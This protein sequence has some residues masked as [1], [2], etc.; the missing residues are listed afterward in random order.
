M[1]VAILSRGSGWH[2]QDLLRAGCSRSLSADALD[3][4]QLSAGVPLRQPLDGYD[5]AIIRTMPAGSL[6]QIIFR[7][8]ALHAAADRGVAVLN[9]PRVIECCVDKYLTTVRLAQRGLPTPATVVCQKAQDA[10]EVFATLGG[11][12][13]VKPLFGAEGRGM[14]RITDHELAWRTFHAIEQTGGVIYLQQFIRHPGWDVRAFV[15]D[16]VVVAAMQRRNA[17][18]WRTNVAQGGTA[19]TIELCSEARELAREAARATGAIIAGV[20]LLHDESGQWYV[21]EVNAV[22]GWRTLAP[23]SGI[24]LA[25]AV[26]D[27]LMQRVHNR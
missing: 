7:M 9:P 20:D 13:V 21:I 25:G 15:I 22:P 11:D 24:D 10:L 26:L 3:F 2:V 1:R 5:A 4:R 27:C 18:D 8:D 12:V 23:L 6:E 16:D 19:Q 14:L 17:L